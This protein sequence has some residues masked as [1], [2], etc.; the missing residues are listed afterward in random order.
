M[1]T[2]WREAECGAGGR[3]CALSIAN[4][5]RRKRSGRQEEDRQAE[6]THRGRGPLRGLRRGAALLC[7]GLPGLPENTELEAE[8]GVHRRGSG[9]EQ[10][11]SQEDGCTGSATRR[12][13]GGVGGPVCACEVVL[14]SQD[15]T[16]PA[17]GPEAEGRMGRLKKPL[18]PLIKGLPGMMVSILSVF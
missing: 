1:G 3:A 2:P 12:Q 17:E 13:H 16:R 10:N 11:C 5:H 18:L 15:S 6:S 4:G 9:N 8:G 14:R 7:A